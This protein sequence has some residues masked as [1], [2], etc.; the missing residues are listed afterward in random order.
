MPFTKG[1]FIL[2]NYS[3]KV[4]ETSEIFDTTFEEVAKKE[5]VF[6]EGEI[7]EPKLIVVGDGWVLEPLDEALLTMK[8]K[9]TQIVEILP[10]KAFGQRNPEKVKRVPLRHLMSKGKNPVVGMRIEYNEKMAIVRSIGAG[11]VY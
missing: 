5:N 10:D 4:K 6:K 11:R 3:A 7:Y 1:D 9:K 8:L 2:L